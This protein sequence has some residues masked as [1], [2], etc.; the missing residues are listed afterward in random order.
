MADNIIFLGYVVERMSNDP[1]KVGY[2]LHGPRATYTLIRQMT[3]TENLFAI[4]SNGNI[5]GVK[6][7]Y[8][9]T[10]RRGMLEVV[11]GL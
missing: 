1:G 2:K 6:G 8:T 11:Q 3:H 4:N 7:N 5:C 10:D 9:F